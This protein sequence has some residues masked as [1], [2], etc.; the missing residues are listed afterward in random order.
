MPL[1]NSNK[2]DMEPNMS[3]IS[4]DF[5]C[6]KVSALG[7]VS[8]IS[9]E[10]DRI[11][12]GPNS[13][14]SKS[15]LKKLENIENE[16]NSCN[17]KTP[18]KTM[19]EWNN[20]ISTQSGIIFSI[21]KILLEEELQRREK[22]RKEVQ[23]KWQ[24]ME[25][26]GTAIQKHISLSRSNMAQERERKSA[27]K[28]AD[29]LAEEERI[30]EQ[31][32]IRRKH[33]QQLHAQR[34]Q[35][36]N[37]KMKRDME[38]CRRKLKEKEE[39]IKKIVILRHEFEVKYY[40]IVI[41]S[42]NFKDK[43][44]IANF[45]IMHSVVL[46]QLHRQIESLDEKIKKG[47]LA[48]TDLYSAETA[49]QQIGEILSSLKV[50][51]DRITAEKIIPVSNA[52]VQS[53]ELIQK[54]QSKSEEVVKIYDVSTADQINN[55]NVNENVGNDKA[56]E[57]VPGSV[58]ESVPEPVPEIVPGTVPESTP[59]T[60]P[61][62]IPEN[63][64]ETGQT[65]ETSTNHQG[66][67]EDTS[68]TSTV[69]LQEIEN[70]IYKYVDKE[71]LQIYIHSQEILENY[72]KNYNE[73][74]RSPS[75][76]KFRFECQKAIN[77]PVNAISV[78]N[79]QHLKDKYERLHN[80]LI[81]RSSPNVGQHPQGAA[82]CKDVLAKK[83]VNQGETLVSSKPKMAFAIATIIVALWNDHGDF[84]ELLL[85]HFHKTC[86]FTVPVFMPKREGQTNEEYFKSL[87]Y[88]YFENGSVEKQDKFL[89][90]MSGLMRL[91]ISI[92]VTSQRKGI[93][94]K[95][96]YGLRHTWRWLATVLN[97]ESQPNTSDLRATLI[98]DVLE[99]AGN[100]LWNVYPKQ[101]HKM[102]MLLANEYYPRI[103]NTDGISDGP[104]VR[105][106]EFL[107]NTL[108]RGSI[109]PPDGYLAPNFW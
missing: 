73:F 2:E 101:F 64:Q 65:I 98:L 9:G 57:I 109:P 87:G 38:E 51:L 6:L 8:R 79:E 107:K 58:P 90:R 108:A 53:T 82:F 88:K 23:R 72:A 83:I 46:K 13:D 25:E 42:K 74:S 86:P 20:K 96:P 21:K 75:T 39:L 41:L 14:S 71:S 28:Y 80:L 60:V 77:I 47:D 63:V 103:Q 7:K 62:L 30:A 31:E 43:N 27:Q 68:S 50:E 33:E 45:F 44:A 91:Y 10:I 48:P 61:E 89:K 36:Q 105:L 16:Q 35:E 40:D 56:Q 94:K 4:A 3:D 24:H 104:L 99:V 54:E 49:V 26:N 19:D 102:L 12:I 93:T 97:S 5:A 37:E 85:A 84:G 81:G 11:T 32:E 17:V 1:S 67:S 15:D 18:Q 59:E 95:H 29:I 78:I 70:N 106:E 66:N 76:K 55:D 100:S 69:P 22:V 92:T 34:A 52:N